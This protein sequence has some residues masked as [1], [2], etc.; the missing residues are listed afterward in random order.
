MQY[1]SCDS[2]RIPIRGRL[3]CPRCERMRLVPRNDAVRRLGKLARR[4]E[5]K[6]ARRMGRYARDDILTEAFKKREQIAREYL[7]N[8]KPMDVRMFLGC[9]AAIKKFG[10]A[11]TALGCRRADPARILG[12]IQKLGNMLHRLEKVPDLEAGT[13]SLLHTEKYSLNALVSADSGGFPLYPNEKHVQAF[14]A[15]SGLGMITQSQAERREAEPS[16]GVSPAA[17]GT[18]KLLT[19]EETIRAQYYHAYM[20]ADMFFGTPVRK[21]YGAPPDL[22]RVTIPPLELKKFVSQ[23]PYDMD[24]ITVCGAGRFEALASKAFG[25]AYRSF[26]RDFVMSSDSARAFPLFLKIG[27]RV[28]VSQFFAEFYSTALLTAVHRKE[29]DRE[30]M[31][32]SRLYES[33]VVPARFRK[34]G[35]AYYPNQMVKDGFEI[36]GIAVSPDTAYVIEAKYW[37]PRKFLGGVGRYRAH[38]DMVRGSI[39]GTHYD[40]G[41]KA[42]K[43]RGVALADKAAWVEKNRAIYASPCGTPVKCALV[44]NTHPVAREYKG[45]AIILVA[46]PDALDAQDDAGGP[47]GGGP[48]ANPAAPGCGRSSDQSRAEGRPGRRR[49]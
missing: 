1:A 43:K 9:S 42:W 3:A 6:L 33:E 34:W 49:K 44:T 41:T 25:G 17:L 13:Y 36:D 19:V 22:D 23:F 12:H 31:R 32:R 28:Y 38:D 14:V 47:P 30:T 16:G 40:R 2:P 37:N 45:C 48:G 24:A 8:W 15:R 27:D 18:K 4:A 46:D 35:F 10:S 26:E 39:E 11:K 5:K 20:F 21:K 7:F 29:L